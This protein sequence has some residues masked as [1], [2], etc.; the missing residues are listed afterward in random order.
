M[1]E[2]TASFVTLSPR[3]QDHVSIFSYIP[4]EALKKPE[5]P[6]RTLPQLN[7]I[8]SVAYKKVEALR[9]TQ[10]QNASAVGT[11]CNN[12]YNRMLTISDLPRHPDIG[13]HPRA[14]PG[15]AVH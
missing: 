9:A 7:N 14:L 3:V 5:T 4:E 11:R 8:R 15:H 2:R 1:I 13:H 12:V 10:I 6:T